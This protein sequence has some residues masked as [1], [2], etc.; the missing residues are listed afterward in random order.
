MIAGLIVVGNLTDLSHI[1]LM[2]NEL[3]I[4]VVFTGA[5]PSIDEGTRIGVDS[6]RTGSVDKSITFTHDFI[7]A[8]EDDYEQAVRK[9]IGSGGQ[10][11]EALMALVLEDNPAELPG[12]LTFWA[13]R[14][15]PLHEITR[16]VLPLVGHKHFAD[17][18]VVCET[19]CSEYQW[20]VGRQ[21]ARRVLPQLAYYRRKETLSLLKSW[22]SSGSLPL[23]KAAAMALGNVALMDLD[24]ARVMVKTILDHP[25]DTVVK[26]APRA[27]TNINDVDRDLA[28]EVV[29][30]CRSFK[31]IPELQ[32]DYRNIFYGLALAAIP[33]Y[34]A[35]SPDLAFEK[36][37][38][39][40]RLINKE[41]LAD[42]NV[43]IA[44]N[45]IFAN[46]LLLAE[47][48]PKRL[49]ASM[50]LLRPFTIERHI[51]VDL[52]V[53]AS[54][55]GAVNRQVA[56]DLFELGETHLDGSLAAFS[57]RIRKK[58]FS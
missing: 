1:S 53:A 51:Q 58:L 43:A 42:T 17:V 9:N 4:P 3:R 13:Q 55:L 21:E 36:V 54:R 30:R 56:R 26:E 48:N 19:L 40:V 15:G 33:G 25:N 44:R 35:L 50:D 23:I 28:D 29:R 7:R 5:T 41:G 24:L 2:L 16:N 47:V 49:T 38:Y 57:E 11:P 32:L 34:L 27:V 18:A 22:I 8:R 12:E 39:A 37:E 14:W 46:V 31:S 20:P 45:Y 6:D 10:V 52:F